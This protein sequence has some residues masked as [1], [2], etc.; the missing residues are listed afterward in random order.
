MGIRRH[1][2]L[3]A[4]KQVFQVSSNSARAFAGIVVNVA[5][6]FL[7]CESQVAGG[8]CSMHC[9]VYSIALFP[10]LTPYISASASASTPVL[11]VYPL[12]CTVLSVACFSVYFPLSILLPPVFA[13]RMCKSSTALYL[14]LPSHV[15]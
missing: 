2:S 3:W 5:T 4:A 11:T 7:V 15:G 6:S 14:L 12:C 8:V 9:L 13:R 10:N 1:P